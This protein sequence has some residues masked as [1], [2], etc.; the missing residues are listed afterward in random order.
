M[1]GIFFQRRTPDISGE[2]KQQMQQDGSHWNCACPPR[3]VNEDIELEEQQ[4][5]QEGLH[6]ELCLSPERGEE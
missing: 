3:G 6:W 1:G 2:E 5:Q 4:M